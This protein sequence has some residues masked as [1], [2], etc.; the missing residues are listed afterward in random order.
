MKEKTFEGLGSRRDEFL[1]RLSRR[2]VDRVFEKVL[3]D[4]PISHFFRWLDASDPWSFIGE[5]AK[6]ADFD[7][8]GYE[9]K[10]EFNKSGIRFRV[11]VSATPFDKNLT[12]TTSLIYQHTTIEYFGKF[13]IVTFIGLLVGYFIHATNQYVYSFPLLFV[14]ILILYGVFVKPVKDAKKLID[15]I[16]EEVAKSMKE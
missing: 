10:F 6:F 7:L 3:K 15:N 4:G 9:H 8:G 11:G 12:V 1:R 5:F 2:M 16:I 13:I 14:L